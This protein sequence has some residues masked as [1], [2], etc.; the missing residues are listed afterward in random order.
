MSSARGW[1][2]RL[3]EFFPCLIGRRRERDVLSFAVDSEA[4]H[5]TL[6]RNR[7]LPESHRHDI[8]LEVYN[9]PTSKKPEGSRKYPVPAH[10]MSRARVPVGGM[11]ST[12]TT[13]YR[14]GSAFPGAYSI[15]LAAIRAPS[16]TRYVQVRKRIILRSL[17]LLFY[18]YSSTYPGT[19]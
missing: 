16:H 1:C 18:T 6:E 2:R 15:K 17:S 9:A 11:D 5:L 3:R 13:L 8:T 19:R 7:P 10:V 14:T 4:H 12:C